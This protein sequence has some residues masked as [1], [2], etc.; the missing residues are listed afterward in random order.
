MD[1]VLIADQDLKET[2]VII[3]MQILHLKTFSPCLHFVQIFETKL[4]PES[5]KQKRI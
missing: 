3:K 4:Y 5:I 1:I 2:L